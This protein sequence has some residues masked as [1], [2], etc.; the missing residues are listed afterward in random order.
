[1]NYV[2]TYL[3]LLSYYI[4]WY[5]I[6]QIKNN[7]SLVD[8]AWGLGIV[9]SAVSS[10]FLSAS[11]SIPSMLITGL[12]LIWGLRLTAYLF[13]RNFNKKEDYRYQSMKSK[14]KRN[15]Q[16]QSFLKVFLL[17][18]IINYIVALPII[19]TNFLEHESKG[20]LSLFLMTIG[21]ILFI[22]GF[23]F[24]VL[25]DHSLASF[26]KDPNNKGKIMQKNVWKYSRHPNYFGE[27]TLWWGI[28]IISLSTMNMI[29]FIGLIGPAVITYSILNITGIP[30]LEKRYKDHVAYQTYAKKTSRFFPRIPKKNI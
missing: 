19:L 10:F 20:N 29:S 25:A 27:V 15:L 23:T 6:A 14:W 16:I 22:V 24:E 8:V 11:Y 1:M 2:Y 28:G 7:D 18:S 12:T 4:L 26:K 5:I 3:I 30:L 13:K 21:S 9:V 17:Q